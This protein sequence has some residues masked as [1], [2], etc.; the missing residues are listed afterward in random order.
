M[1]ICQYCAQKDNS[2]ALESSFRGPVELSDSEE[3]WKSF[4]RLR[5]HSHKFC[6]VL[7]LT[8]PFFYRAKNLKPKLRV[9]DS[10]AGTLKA[11][12]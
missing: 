10:S 3:N 12:H 5:R 9:M 7:V 6:C 8:L 1:L 4:E 11:G 2:R